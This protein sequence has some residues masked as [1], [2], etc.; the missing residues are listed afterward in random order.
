[1]HQSHPNLMDPV[2]NVPQ[3]DSNKPVRNAIYIAAIP[4]LIAFSD[5][6]KGPMFNA[7]GNAFEGAALAWSVQKAGVLIYYST[8]E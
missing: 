7:L 5:I 8:T 6:V 4:K 2:V 1:M 3:F